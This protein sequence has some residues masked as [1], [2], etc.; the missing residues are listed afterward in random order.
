MPAGIVVLIVVASLAVCFGLAVWAAVALRRAARASPSIS[1]S[2]GTRGRLWRR[3]FAFLVDVL[4]LATIVDTGRALMTWRAGEPFEPIVSLGQIASCQSGWVWRGPEPPGVDV[5]T[6]PTATFCETRHLPFGI[7]Y[8]VTLERVDRQGSVTT[9]YKM[10]F[11][12]TP[13]GILLPLSYATALAEVLAWFGVVV[14]AA[15]LEATLGA[16]PGK[17]L[18]RL[19][20]RTLRGATPSLRAT[21]LRN[22]VKYLPIWLWRAAFIFSIPW[23]NG[24]LLGAFSILSL[25]FLAFIVV[26]FLGFPVI[27]L[28]W[29]PWV[30]RGPDYGCMEHDRLAETDV[31]HMEVN[32]RAAFA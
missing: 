11:P 24:G 13:E 23:I 2:G 17:L 30:R 14:V 16:G 8:T 6:W 19:R 5:S 18:F 9:T 31:V 1:V 7:N 3:G 21:L 12:T 26:F 29:L 25:L 32:S 20:V 27:W 22:G 28:W 15:L 10:A 4:M